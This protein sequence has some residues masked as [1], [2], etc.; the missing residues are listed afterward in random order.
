MGSKKNKNKPKK[1]SAKK[2]KYMKFKKE[3]S[4]NID[5]SMPDLDEEQMKVRRQSDLKIDRFLR[6]NRAPPNL[7]LKDKKAKRK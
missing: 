5:I 2:E 3:K 6:F 1:I 7:S 4:G